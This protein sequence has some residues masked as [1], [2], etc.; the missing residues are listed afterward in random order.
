M[1]DELRH[2]LGFEVQVLISTVESLKKLIEETDEISYQLV[3][4]VLGSQ[5][6]SAAT[7]LEAISRVEVEEFEE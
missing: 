4:H 1:K 2:R 7:F 5:I 3:L 6:E